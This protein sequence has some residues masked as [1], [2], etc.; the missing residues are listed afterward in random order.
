MV[1]VCAVASRAGPATTP[2]PKTS[3]AANRTTRV[4][5]DAKAVTDWGALAVMRTYSI[6]RFNKALARLPIP[7][8]GR[9]LPYLI[10]HGRPLQQV[11]ITGNSRAEPKGDLFQPCNRGDP[12]LKEAHES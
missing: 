10:R 4:L 1:I 8:R 2:R 6:R 11:K 3:A 5:R 9:T 7:L 12:W